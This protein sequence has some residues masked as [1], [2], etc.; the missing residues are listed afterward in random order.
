MLHRRAFLV[1]VAG[2]LAPVW[3]DAQP[4]SVPRLGILLFGTPDTDPNLP[5]FRQGLEALGY[6]EPR[7]IAIQ[8]R[9]AAGQV[10]RL[11]SI[12]AELVATGPDVILALGGDV[13]PF[14]RAA[15]TTIPIVAVVSNDPLQS[16]LVVSLARPTGN[17]T[18]LTFVSSDLAAKRLQLLKDMAPR[19]SRVG[20][21]W[22]PDHV[23]PEYRE[24]QRAARDLGVQLQSLE[25]RTGGE[26]PMAFQTAATEH[27]EALLA[28]SS[29]LMTTNRQQVLD[30]AA[31]NRLIL[32][33][34]WGP[35]AKE[36]ALFSY[37]P[38]LNVVT[39]RAAD[40]VKKILKGAKPA[41]LPIEQPT[42]FDFVVNLKTAKALGL[43]I[44]PSVLARADEI[45]H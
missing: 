14:V 15:T 30:F 23:D 40:Y 42:K 37:G 2:V 43:T 3:S 29:R 41:D 12:A 35:W 22:N 5:A 34:G 44:L 6:V 13:A 36:G 26:F 27:A 45:I 4:A 19:V 9:Y 32:G 7:T 8:Y 33:G 1:A 39:R 38:D 21:L 24:S 18:G 25:V 31:Q 16:G 11:P 17:V 20:I 28:V 10:V